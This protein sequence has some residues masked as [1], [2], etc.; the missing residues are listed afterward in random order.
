MLY[1]YWMA[2]I[3]MTCAAQTISALEKLPSKYLVSYGDPDAPIKI[4][5]YF[6]FQCPH[7]ITLF[8]K[9]FKEIES[10]FIDTK[11]VFWVFH[12]V[13][14]DLVTVQG[15]ICMAA[16]N[17]HQKT[18]YLETLLEEAEPDSPQNTSLIM[19]TV[20]EVFKK[21]IPELQ[22]ETFIQN[23]EAFLDAFTFLSQDEKIMAVPTIEVDSK[24]FPKDVPDFKFVQSMVTP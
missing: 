15:M 14:A 8:R 17:D 5:E 1:T 3:S 16:L 24:L 23:T 10:K 22:D 19:S 7:C 9:E 21:P 12:P 2:M 11:R 13:P 20:M 6:S 4:V 18:L